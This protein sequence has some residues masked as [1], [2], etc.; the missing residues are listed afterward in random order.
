MRKSFLAAALVLAAVSVRAE[1]LLPTGEGTTWEY[2]STETLTGAAPVRSVVTVRAGKQL[3]DGKEVV[4]LETLSGNAVSK[5]EL[6]SVNENGVMCLARSGKDGKIAKLN[7]P[8]PVIVGPL[9]VG[10]AWDSSGEVAGIKMR[11]HFTVVGEE[12][13]TVPAGRFRAFH[14][15]CED[16]SLMSIKLDRWFVPGTGFVK[17]T[18]VLRGPGVLQRITLELNK[19]TEVLSKPAASPPAA[20]PKPTEQRPSSTPVAAVTPAATPSAPAAS[21]EEQTTPPPRKLTVEVSSDPAGGLKTQFKSDVANIY[22]RWQ[23]HDLPD[24]ATVR[25]AWVAEDVGDL[26]EPN[27]V[28]DETESVAPAPDASARFTLGRPPDGWA[29]GKYRVEFYVN[30]LLVETVPVTIG[31]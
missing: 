10:A 24:G 9:K 4:K 8:E 25:V 7:P 12:N 30:D 19:M 3:F 11:Q 16:S 29:E 23:G 1:A 22:V 18:A 15:Q 17:E 13:V 21:P 2:D 28:I 6:V 14:L 5:T 26:V 27:F 31:K 20:S